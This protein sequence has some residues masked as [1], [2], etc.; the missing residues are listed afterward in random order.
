[1]VHITFYWIL[2]TYCSLHAIISAVVYVIDR[3]SVEGSCTVL[4]SRLVTTYQIT[5]AYRPST[6]GVWTSVNA[7]SI[8]PLTK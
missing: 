7:P 1:M 6:Y 8:L 4:V 3:E 2:Y 5:R